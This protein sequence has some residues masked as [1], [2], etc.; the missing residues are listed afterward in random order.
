VLVVVVL[1][2]VGS[3]VPVFARVLLPLRR[4][5][6]VPFR[7]VLALE[8][9][10]GTGRDPVTAPVP[11]GQEPAEWESRSRS[12]PPFVRDRRG[13]NTSDRTRPSWI[14]PTCSCTTTGEG[15]AVMVRMGASH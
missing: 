5:Q 14:R 2:Q 13:A 15:K 11:R 8:W 7:R 12:W 3:A 4:G 1:F 9:E 6:G 10:S